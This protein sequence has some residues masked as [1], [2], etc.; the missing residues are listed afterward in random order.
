[1]ADD[2]SDGKERGEP[3]R[4]IIPFEPYR[5]IARDPLPVQA[6]VDRRT[7]KPVKGSGED[8][9]AEPGGA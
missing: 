3:D 2:D 1:M 8:G 4:Q 6:K 7:G 9:S 5:K